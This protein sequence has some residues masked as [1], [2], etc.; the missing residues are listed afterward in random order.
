MCH[1]SLR[2]PPVREDVIGMDGAV[3]RIARKKLGPTPGVRA[4]QP[5]VVLWLGVEFINHEAWGEILEE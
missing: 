3:G 5:I 4:S 1:S 2:P